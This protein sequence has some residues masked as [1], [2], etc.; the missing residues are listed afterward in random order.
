MLKPIMSWTYLRR[1]LR[2]RG[3]E[4]YHC[5]DCGHVWIASALESPARCSQRHCRAWADYSKR[6]SKPSRKHS[7]SR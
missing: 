4:I 7:K 2:A 6:T 1:V 3:E 5:L